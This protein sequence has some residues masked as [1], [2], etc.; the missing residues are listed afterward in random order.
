M[1][2]SPTIRIQ[3]QEWGVRQQNESRRFGTIWWFQA[4]RGTPN[5]VSERTSEVN[6]NHGVST[7]GS[8]AGSEKPLQKAHGYS[9]GPFQSH[10]LSISR[11]LQRKMP[12]KFDDSDGKCGAPQTTGWLSIVISPV[13]IRHWVDPPFPDTPEYHIY[14]LMLVIANFI[15]LLH[16]YRTL[17][18]RLTYPS[19]WWLYSYITTKASKSMCLL[20]W[21]D[22]THECL[23]VKDGKIPIFNEV[24]WSNS[25]N[26]CESPI[27]RSFSLGKKN[28]GQP[29]GFKRV[30][31][32]D[33]L[34][35][36]V[37]REGEVA[38]KADEVMQLG[39]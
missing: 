31:F 23:S 28:H 6:E 32:V 33:E 15:P 36:C 8:V 17:M 16:P 11:N 35:A 1:R 2:F 9:I 19:C 22:Q 26:T 34:E 13:E 25:P 39:W 29:G 38:E 14:W 7:T 12:N 20:V 4:Y 30:S 5:R 21:Y 10:N 27:L 3:R 37:A 24:R 18:L